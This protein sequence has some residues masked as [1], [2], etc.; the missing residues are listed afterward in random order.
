[1]AKVIHASYSRYFPYC[2]FPYQDSAFFPFVSTCSLSEAMNIFWRIKT[3]N[4]YGTYIAGGE[5]PGERD[6]Q[7]VVESAAETEK[8]LVCNPG[9]YIASSLNILE[10]IFSFEEVQT[11]NGLYVARILFSGFFIDTFGPEGFIFRNP[12]QT[13]SQGTIN[14]FGVTMWGEVGGNASFNFEA[15]YW[16]YN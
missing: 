4:F 5:N 1:M 8:N 7:M 11:L 9:W 15:E 12:S 3:I 13:A 16:P 2:L 14:F 10:P 6:W